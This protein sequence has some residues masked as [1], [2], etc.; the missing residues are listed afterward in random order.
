MGFSIYAK[1]EP[2]CDVCGLDSEPCEMSGTATGGFS[3]EGPIQELRRDGWLVE[4]NGDRTV[5]PEC[6]EEESL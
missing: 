6:V 4:N 5:C 3:L 2:Q 1:A